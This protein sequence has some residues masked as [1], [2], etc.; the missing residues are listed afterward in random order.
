MEDGQPQE[1]LTVKDPADPAV[2]EY[3]R[4]LTSAEQQS[5]ADFDKAILALSGGALA[6]SFSFIKDVVGP[7]NMIR[8]GF[9]L[10]S[11]IVWALSSCSVLLSFFTSQLALR[12]TIKELDAHGKVPPRPGGWYDRLTSI[13]NI[14]GLV[15]FLLGI[16]LM[17]FF[18]HFNLK[19]HMKTKPAETIQLNEGQ[20]VPQPPQAIKA[21]QYVPVPPANLVGKPSPSQSPEPVQNVQATPIPNQIPPQQQKNEITN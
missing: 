6:I 2:A 11:W 17:I 4:L 7:D 10:W 9:L 13:F 20:L 12:K 14:S 16:F 8:S 15:L 1:V 19:D 21:G 3:R 5:Q 18:L